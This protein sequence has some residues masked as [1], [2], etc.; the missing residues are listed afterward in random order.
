MFLCAEIQYKSFMGSDP[1]PIWFCGLW[2]RLAASNSTHTSNKTAAWKAGNHRESLPAQLQRAGT[3]ER[4]PPCADFKSCGCLLSWGWASAMVCP[5]AEDLPDVLPRRTRATLGECD[6]WLSSSE[7]RPP[8]G[9]SFIL[10]P[11]SSFW[12]ER[13][14]ET[15]AV[16]DL[17]SFWG[18]L[19]WESAGKHSD[20]VQL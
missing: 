4:K 8:R 12:W 18:S 10:P 1:K 7:W 5:L 3:T 15:R 17:W 2:I 11:N 14:W 6:F 13:G 16:W 9:W 19:R 20:H